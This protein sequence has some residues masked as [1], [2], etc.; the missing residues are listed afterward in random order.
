[1]NTTRRW[2]RAFS[3]DESNRSDRAE[4]RELCHPER[5]VPSAKRRACVVEGSLLPEV[6]LA[7]G[8]LRLVVSFTS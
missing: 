4:R 6:E 5:S 7:V 3:R 8:I 2:P 1:M